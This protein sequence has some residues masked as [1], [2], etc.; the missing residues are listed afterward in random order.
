MP[1][2]QFAPD[3]GDYLAERETGE[4]DLFRRAKDD[5]IVTTAPPATRWS[6]FFRI[7]TPAVLLA[8]EEVIEAVKEDIALNP[9]IGASPRVLLGL[10]ALASVE[11][12]K[13]QP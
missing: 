1:W 11:A 7:P 12:A 4:I 8:M 9:E 10:S 3:P 5:T 13:D 2:T 6:R